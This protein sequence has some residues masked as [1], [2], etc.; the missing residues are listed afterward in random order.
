MLSKLSNSHR[1]IDSL[2]FFPCWTKRNYRYFQK[3]Y[4]Y[5]KYFLMI[6]CLY[7][8]LY[9]ISSLSIPLS[10]VI[11]V[12]SISVVNCAAMNRDV[13]IFSHYDFLWI[14]AQEWDCKI[15]WHLYFLF[16][17][18]HPYYSPQWLHHTHS[19]QPYRKVLFSPHGLQ[20]LFF[21]D[22]LSIA[23]LTSVR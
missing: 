18:E 22:F 10:M 5:E 2:F 9:T 16:F 1:V 6:K 20:H 12:A 19:H 17:K 4:S 14:Y 11:Q 3:C 13:C 7:I 23:I 15:V 21:V 8:L